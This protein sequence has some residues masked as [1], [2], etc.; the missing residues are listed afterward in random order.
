MG[1]Q[2]RRAR[3]RYSLDEAALHTVEATLVLR[4]GRSWPNMADRRPLHTW[5]PYVAA[6]VRVT[7]R[8]WGSAASPGWLDLFQSVYSVGH[9][10]KSETK[11]YGQN[12]RLKKENYS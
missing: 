9:Y 8:S 6:S 1:I 5:R 11:N 7:P 2:N 12:D 4:S 3:E 10:L